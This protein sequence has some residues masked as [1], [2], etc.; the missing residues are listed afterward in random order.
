VSRP[1]TLRDARRAL[2][3]TSLLGTVGLLPSGECGYA[4]EGTV[5]LSQRYLDALPQCNCGWYHRLR[6]H[7][8]LSVLDRLIS[9]Y[10]AD[11]PLADAPAPP[12]ERGEYRPKDTDEVGPVSGDPSDDATQHGGD[13]N[14]GECDAPALTSADARESASDQ[15]QSGSDSHASANREETADVDGVPGTSESTRGSEEQSSQDAPGTTESPAGATEEHEPHGG[16]ATSEG[17]DP[18]RSERTDDESGA[19]QGSARV[20]SVDADDLR[21]D[22]SDVASASA[23]A[24]AEE[25]ATMTACDDQGGHDPTSPAETESETGAEPASGQGSSQSDAGLCESESVDD[26]GSETPAPATAKYRTPGGQH[27][28]PDEVRRALRDAAKPAARE[29]AR[30][31]RRLLESIEPGGTEETPRV[32]GRRLVREIA[33]RRYALSRTRRR[34]ADHAIVV[35]AVDVSGSCSACCSEL[36]ACAVAT[37]AV[38]PAVVLVDHSNGMVW[39]D[40]SSEATLPERINRI[41]QGRRVAAVI[42]LGD[43]DA[44][45]EYQALCESGA[46]LYWLDSYSASVGPRPASK[47]LRAGARGWRRQPAAWWQGVNDARSTAIAMRAMRRGQ[48][49][50]ANCTS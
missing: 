45:Y 7:E 38:D 26:S 41:A 29:V 46:E 49:A 4:G 31:L 10:G 33:S 43:W 28:D 2:S 32:D 9:R 50:T 11:A 44:G 1:W 21:G 39:D 15:Q 12:C 14:S 30:A 8:A 3:R 35:I 6:R 17:S 23:P 22:P 19:P 25:I 20:S 36:W 47:N 27:L 24:A 16:E 5:R 34:E 48:T 40:E 42:A 13:G 37:A 18:P